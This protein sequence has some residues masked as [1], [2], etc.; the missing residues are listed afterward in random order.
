[1]AFASIIATAVLASSGAADASTYKIIHEFEVLKRP[2]GSLVI[3]AAG[4]LYGTTSG[5]GSAACNGGCGVAWKLAPNG[6]L[7]V[8]HQFTGGA[9]GAFPVGLI[10]G[11]AGNL[12]G[13]A[14]GGSATCP[15]GCGVVFKLAPNPDG[16]W[17]E[18]VLY[19]FSGGADG[20]GP[21]GLIFDAAGNL[22]GTTVGGGSTACEGGCGVVFKL[23]PD[24][25]G[26]WTESVLY[27]FGGSVFSLADIVPGTLILDAAGN[28]YGTTEGGGAYGYGSVFKLAPNP[29]GT[30]TESVLHSFSLKDGIVPTDSLV[31]DAKGNLYGTTK[32]YGPTKF[33]EGVVFKLAPNPDG[34]W[35]ESVL[36]N[37]TGRADGGN[38]GAGLTFDAVGNLYGTTAGGGFN[39][40]GVV[41]KLTPTSDGWSETVL[42]EF[43]GRA[44]GPMAPVLFDKKGNLYGTT[45][46]GTG[47]YGVVF[48]ITP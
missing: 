3:D 31:L 25:D 7:T 37:F 40:Y 22:Y 26:T 1:V 12:Y 33:E 38:P 47:N 44:Q 4:N 13:T 17:T 23:A 16:T 35:T 39:G 14:G 15:G 41:F 2:S 48:K 9:D 8:L 36:Y 18:S 28:L 24:P 10:F 42:H 29:D 43:L 19:T 6:R 45:Y 27:S 46:F 21:V 11:A 5:G 32:Q 30:W 20:V 34:T